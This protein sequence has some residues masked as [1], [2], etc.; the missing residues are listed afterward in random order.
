[1][2]FGPASPD[3]LPGAR[4][5]VATC[6]AIQPGE[7]VTLIADR[8]SGEVAASLDRALTECR[9]IATCLSIEALAARPLV[10]APPEVLASLEPLGVR[11]AGK[12][13]KKSGGGFYRWG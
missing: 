2:I 13:G 4:N 5:A 9:A 1:M 3:L 10:A 8:A 11:P 7:R 6:L 12:L